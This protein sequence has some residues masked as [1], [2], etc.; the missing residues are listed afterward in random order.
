MKLPNAILIGAQKAGTT[1]L[2]DWLGQHPDIFADKGMKEYNYFANN[3]LYC[4]GDKWF[5][6]AFKKHGNEKIILHGYVNYIYFSDISAKRIFQFNNQ[7][8]IIVV[9]RNPIDR[10][11][12]AY[13]DAKKVAREESITFEEAI[14]KEPIYLKKG[15]LE[16]QSHLTYLDHGYYTKQLTDFYKYFKKE[17]IKVILF[18]D[19]VQEPS[20][21]MQELFNFLE[22]DNNFCPDFKVQNEAGLPRSI[23]VQKI[24]Q[25][26]KVPKIIRKNLPQNIT[27]SFKTYLIRQLNI[28]KVTYPKL[29]NETRVYLNK[30]YKDEVYKLEKMIHKDLSH[31]LK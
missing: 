15:T 14:K 24:L 16:E 7:C 30:L 20:K 17:Q 10:A 18:D 8:K 29:S 21:I 26:I 25:N 3:E 31:W 9:L 1:S 23:V 6:R 11:Y 4:E 28:K 19:L 5:Q 12:S 13:W 22:V 27:S 2:Y